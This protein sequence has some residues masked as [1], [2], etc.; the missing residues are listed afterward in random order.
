M[1][2]SISSYLDRRRRLQLTIQTISPP[3]YGSRHS[4]DLHERWRLQRV[5]KGQGTR[6]KE[7]ATKAILGFELKISRG[8]Q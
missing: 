8:V 2:M 5:L 3:H 1:V 7:Q 4:S 6:D